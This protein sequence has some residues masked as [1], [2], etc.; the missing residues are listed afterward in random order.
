MP[1][2]VLR[3][4][5]ADVDG[6]PPWDEACREFLDGLALR[7]FSPR[8]LEWYTF[9]LNPFGRYLAETLGCD[10]PGTVQEK[11]VVAFLSTVGTEGLGGRPPVGAKRLNDYREGLSQFYTWLQDRGYVTDNPVR[12]VK[13]IRQRRQLIEAFSEAQV[14][15]LLEQP[16]RSTFVGLRDYCFML[17]L[18]DAGLRLSEGL[19]LKVEDLDLDG[20]AAKVMGKGNKERR[21]GLS[22]RLLAALKPYLRKRDAAVTTLGLP[23]SPWVFPNDIGG[24]LVPKTMQQH[25]KRYGEAAGIR[26]VRVSPHTL[27]HTHAVTFVRAGGDPFTLQKVL[28]HSSLEMSRRYC[29][30]ADSD[31]L[32]R[33]RELT[34]LRTMD[35]SITPARRIPRSAMSSW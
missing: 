28:G 2:H 7:R 16:D 11:H 19:S 34:P 20:M 13:K 25:L 30:L 3:Y 9:I 22:P 5:P 15:A 4:L 6:P 32:K 33:Q 18:L 1:P 23:E 12:R 8:T 29:E 21:L 31:V 35:I 10:D 24:R 14:K 27:R 17:T 26:G